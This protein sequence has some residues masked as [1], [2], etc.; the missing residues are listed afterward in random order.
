[1]V[2]R[3]FVSQ[4]KWASNDDDHVPTAKIVHGKKL[5]LKSEPGKGKHSGR[6]LDLPKR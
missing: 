4:A 6:G 2:S 3:F 5:V 1:M